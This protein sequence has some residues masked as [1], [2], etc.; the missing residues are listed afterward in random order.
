MEKQKI[1]IP[2]KA[3]SDF[4]VYVNKFYGKSGIYGKEY[5]GGF[6]KSEINQAVKQYIEDDRTVWGGGDSVDR[7]LM[8]NRFLVPSKYPNKKLTKNPTP[9]KISKYSVWN[10]KKTLPKLNSFVG[11]KVGDN[12]ALVT[13]VDGREYS[14]KSKNKRSSNFTFKDVYLSD[15]KPLNYHRIPESVLE[16]YGLKE[17]EINVFEPSGEYND[18]TGT[19]Y[20]RKELDKIEEKYGLNSEEYNAITLPK[21]FNWKSAD[22]VYATDPSYLLSNSNQLLTK[23]GI[24]KEKY[25]ISFNSGFG[26]NPKPLAD[27]YGVDDETQYQLLYIYEVTPQTKEDIKEFEYDYELWRSEKSDL[28]KALEGVEIAINLSGKTKELLKAKK[29]IEIAINLL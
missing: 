19:Y 25:G 4:G 23:R 18:E 24:D 9:T 8:K 10:D 26:K 16:E 6:S 7:E 12:I 3:I 28:E 27:A 29:G 20:T 13:K 22:K 14:I 17:V 5:D 11:V 21:N 15:I 2:K 1:S